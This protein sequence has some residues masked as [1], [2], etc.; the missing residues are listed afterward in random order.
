LLASASRRINHNRVNNM[1]YRDQWLRP[2]V[3]STIVDLTLE[4]WCLILGARST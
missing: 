1:A 4:E 2:E 3:S